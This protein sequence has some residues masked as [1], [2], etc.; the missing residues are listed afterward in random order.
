MMSAADVNSVATQPQEVAVAVLRN[1]VT[2]QGF[3]AGMTPFEPP[4]HYCSFLLDKVRT[5]ERK[6]A[7]EPCARCQAHC[8]YATFEGIKDS[9]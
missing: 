2:K 9:R 6:L 4:A 8:P 1:A 3:F 5:G 7:L